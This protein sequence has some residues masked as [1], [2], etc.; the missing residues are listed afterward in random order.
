MPIQGHLLSKPARN[1]LN[2][3]TPKDGGLFC[4][5]FPGEIPVGVGNFGQQINLLQNRLGIPFEL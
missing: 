4:L 1:L 2:E 5:R 3:I